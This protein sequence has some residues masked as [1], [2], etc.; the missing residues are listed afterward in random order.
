MTQQTTKSRT[1]IRV[2][3]GVVLKAGMNKSRIVT[4]TRL[5]RESQFQKVIRKRVKYAVHDE[6]NQSHVGDRIR[7]IETGPLSR[8]KRWR[9]IGIVEK[10]RQ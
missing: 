5:V 9:M 2:R 3:E 10:A 4:V 7:I 6:K 1:R 8:T